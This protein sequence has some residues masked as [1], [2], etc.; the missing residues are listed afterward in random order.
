M[1]IRS[2]LLSLI[3]LLWSGWAAAQNISLNPIYGSITLSAGFSPD[4]HVVRLSAGGSNDARSV[5]RN[6]RGFISDAPDYRLHY[7]AGTILPLIISTQSSADTTLVINGPDGQ[8]YCD[9]DSGSSLNAS[10]R[11]TRGLSGQYD[12]WV[13]TYSSDGLQSAELHISELHSQ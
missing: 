1:L 5:N 13:G 12:I 7:T 10:I 2:A 3:C 6:C 4:P 11:F 8:W 9:D